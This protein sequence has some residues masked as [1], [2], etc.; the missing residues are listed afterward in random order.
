MPARFFRRCLPLLLACALPVLAGDDA[1]ARLTFTKLFRERAPEYVRVTVTEDGRATYQGGTEDDPGE[2]ESFRLSAEV[3]ARMFALAAELNNFRGVALEARQ[4]VANLGRKTFIFERGGERSEVTYNYTQN[5]AGD[6]LQRLF[7]K[8]ARGRHL[9]QQLEARL[10]YDRL[11]VL[12]TLREFEREF[13]TGGLVDLEQFVPVLQSIGA[14]RQV[15]RLAQTRAQRLLARIR[16][17]GRRLQIEH[18][19]QGS[20]WYLRLAVDDGGAAAYE[21]RR[22][23]QPPV[24]RPLALPPAVTAR[25][26]ELARQANYFRGQ[27]SSAYAEAQLNGYRLLYE[28]GAE[29]NEVA[30]TT[31]P[32]AV[33]AE[34]AYL[35]QRVVRQEEFRQRL[36]AAVEEKSVTLQVVLQELEA[37]VQAGGVAEPKDFVPLLEKIA[38]AG[39]THPRVREQA[40]RLLARIRSGA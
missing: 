7:E 23:N 1:A 6:E 26:W 36:Q 3:T 37:A 4:Q 8:I 29:H 27:A 33:L 39:D 40:E 19:D 34:I 22:F 13:N 25:L 16:G 30:F 17:G 38:G 5:H 31:A 24:E 28:A 14:D 21:E 11:G 32:D 20:G 10:V 9:S 35:F 15:M 12:E 18:G 2:P